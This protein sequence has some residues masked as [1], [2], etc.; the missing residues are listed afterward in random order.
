[1][2]KHSWHLQHWWTPSASTRNPSQSRG[3]NKEDT[4]GGVTGTGWEVTGVVANLTVGPDGCGGWAIY[5]RKGGASSQEALTYHGGKAPLERIL[6]GCTTTKAPKVLA[7]DIGSSW[8]LLVPKEH[9]APYSEIVLLMASLWDSPWSG[10]I[11]PM[12]PG[13]C[14][15]VSAG[16][17]R[18]IFGWASGRYQPLYH[19][20]KKGD[21]YAQRHSVSLA[22]M[23]ESISII[24]NLLPK[25]CF[26]L[27][28]VVG[29][30]D[31]VCTRDGNLVWVLL[32]AMIYC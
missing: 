4:G 29:V 6:V 14:H 8:N 9:R 11:W 22:H 16:S 23:W 12:L 27:P 15:I 26:S 28:L 20:C 10:Q 18:G 30:W 2:Y 13:T 19:T 7:G 1:M 3:N 31:F 5:I 25:V 24:R 21:N 17:C 32:F